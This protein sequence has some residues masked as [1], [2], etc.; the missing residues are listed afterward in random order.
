MNDSEIYLVIDE[1]KRIAAAQEKIAAA[2]VEFQRAIIAAFTP[3]VPAMLT[4]MSGS[5][6]FPKTV[7][8]V[9]QIEI[10]DGK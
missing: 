3:L 1:L 8:P 4:M 5:M 9:P 2:N 10:A 7:I 6:S